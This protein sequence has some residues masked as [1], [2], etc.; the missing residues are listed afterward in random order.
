MKAVRSQARP[1]G[2][3]TLLELMIAISIFGVGMLSLNAMLLHAMWGSGSG[4][5]TTQASAIA[6]TRMEQLNRLPWTSLAP[7]AGWS[8]AV[9]VHNTV[10]S[11]AS[12]N[13][14]TYAVDWRITDLVVGWTRTLDVRV[15]WNEPGRGNRDVVFTSIRFNREGA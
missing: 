1:E 2:G 14:E 15:S 9:Q 5:H 10:Q 6:E 8:A 4:R 3:F 12:F 13:E 7:T 11:D